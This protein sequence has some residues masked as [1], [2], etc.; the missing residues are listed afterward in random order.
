MKAKIA[1]ILAEN[2]WT[3]ADLAKFLGCTRQSIWHWETGISS[4]HAE[5]KHKLKKL[6]R[7][8]N[9]YENLRRTPI[10]KS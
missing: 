7:R 5:F 8:V 1:K 6:S 2:L 4:P 3:K 10:K 9:D